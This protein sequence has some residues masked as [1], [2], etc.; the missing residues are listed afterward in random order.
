MN[1]CDFGWF[2]DSVVIP[3]FMRTESQ[4]LWS[5]SG[6]SFTCYESRQSQFARVEEGTPD[7]IF[8]LDSQKVFDKVSHQNS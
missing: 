6:T 5:P 2:P 4:K 3:L 8:C 7:F 1:I